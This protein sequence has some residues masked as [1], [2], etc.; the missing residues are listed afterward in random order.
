MLQRIL[1]SKQHNKVFCCEGSKC[2]V[3]KGYYVN[4]IHIYFHGIIKWNL[5][6]IHKEKLSVSVAFVQYIKKLMKVYTMKIGKKQK[7]QFGIYDSFTFLKTTDTR[8]S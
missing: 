4:Y 1:H 5:Q 3:K 2:F 8:V 6:N 7:Q